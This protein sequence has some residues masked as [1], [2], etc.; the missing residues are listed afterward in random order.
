MMC[1]L[2][3]WPSK[4]KIEEENKVPLSMRTRL[5]SKF[6]TRRPTA[7]QSDQDPI[8]Q[9]YQ[10]RKRAIKRPDSLTLPIYKDVRRMNTR[11]DK[12]QAHSLVVEE[13]EANKVKG[14]YFWNE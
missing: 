3:I 7:A 6:S 13:E 1:I 8:I 2:I 11:I 5:V 14:L 12:K 4:N 10:N 9:V